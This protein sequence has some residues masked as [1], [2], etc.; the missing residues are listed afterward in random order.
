MP[1]PLSDSD[2]VLAAR[3]GDAR[4]FDQ[5]V[6]RHQAGLRAVAARY[7]GSSDQVLDVVQDAFLNAFQALD[8][9]D[10]QRPF[11]PWVRTICRNR[12]L[13][14]LRDRQAHR[15]V[16]QATIDSAL[17]DA[18]PA[19]ESADDDLRLGAM[20]QC[21][22]ILGQPQRTMLEQR[23]LHGEAVQ[24]IAEQAGRS[25]NAVSMVLLRLRTALVECVERR[26]GRGGAT[27]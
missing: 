6:E 24:D 13:N 8:S 12:A 25:P 23:Y 16:G 3:A 19:T 4:A 22:E 10:A 14:V 18:V 27:S 9:F 7:L 17:A 15:T 26:L 11:G 1:E 21:L 2:L 5:L 20:Q